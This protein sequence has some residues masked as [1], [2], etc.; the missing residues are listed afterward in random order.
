MNSIMSRF[1]NWWKQYGKIAAYAFKAMDSDNVRM[2]ASGMVYSSLVAM[3]PCITFLVAFLSLFGLLEPFLSLIS[4]L[5]EDVFGTATGN[6]IMGYI[7]Q[8]SS[9]AMSLGI[10][11]LLSFI[12]TGIFLVDKIYTSINHI[13]RIRPTS[14]AMRRFSVF[15]TFIIIFALIIAIFLSFHSAVTSFIASITVGKITV[16]G[17]PESL[18]TIAVIWLFLMFLYYVVPSAKI[19]PGSA[20]VGAITGTVAL[21]I[22]TNIFQRLTYL[23]VSQ[24]I[25][26]GSM[27]S[28]FISLLF[29][30]ICWYIIFYCAEMVYI[31]QFKPERE[32]ISGHIHPPFQ[33]I[34]EA[35]TVVLLIAYKHRRGEGASTINE[36]MKHLRVPSSVISS[37]LSDLENGGIILSVDSRRNAYVPYRPMT[38]VRVSDVIKAVYGITCDETLGEAIAEKFLG[39]GVSGLGDM[40]MNDL[41]EK[42]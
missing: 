18:R 38:E 20:C 7:R 3:I 22:A 23:M 16:S 31:Y 8:F 30:Y 32:M 12:I 15:L 11:G 33:Q 25:I 1:G 4:L 13:Y 26:Y 35:L 6:E 41:L 27:A 36:L 19:R 29:I 17:V 21:I 5:F 42:V 37:Y 40:T 14:S 2:V 34:A 28:L 10:V 24:S 39:Y 9:N